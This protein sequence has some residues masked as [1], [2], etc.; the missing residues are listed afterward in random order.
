MHYCHC[1]MN[2]KLNLKNWKVL[3]WK[4]SFSSLQQQHLL[5]PCRSQLAANLLVLFLRDA[6]LKKMNWLLCRL[7]WP[8]KKVTYQLYMIF[9]FL[10]VNQSAGLIC[11][12]TFS[13]VTCLFYRETIALLK[14]SSLYVVWNEFKGC[15]YMKFLFSCASRWELILIG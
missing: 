5:L 7:R 8:F 4:N 9:P 12:V 11:L 3:S 14:G 10:L 6:L 2:W 13:G 15:L 1:R